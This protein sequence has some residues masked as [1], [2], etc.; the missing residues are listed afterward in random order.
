MN[1]RRRRSFAIVTLLAVS[2]LLAAPDGC[3]FGAGNVPIGHNQPDPNAPGGGKGR[4]HHAAGAPGEA[5]S[6][7]EAGGP[8]GGS[9]P[10][11]SAGMGGSAG[12]SGSAGTGGSVDAGG[13]GEA[14]GGGTS[15]NPPCVE[16]E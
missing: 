8:S 5:G 13:G 4:G 11:G 7:G 9:S 6:P 1:I 14:G 10:G 16:G 3:Q 12:T 2:P 15:T